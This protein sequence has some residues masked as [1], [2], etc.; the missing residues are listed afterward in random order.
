MEKANFLSTAKITGKKGKKKAAKHVIPFSE[1]KR[2]KDQC[3]STKENRNILQISGMSIVN[4]NKYS[5]EQL[6]GK[7][8]TFIFENRDHFISLEIR[9]TLYFY[10]LHDFV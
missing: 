3:V 6:K 4:K 7:Y 9:L 10:T 5:R 2:I 1:L 8:F